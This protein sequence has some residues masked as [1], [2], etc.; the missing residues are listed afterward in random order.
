MDQLKYRE[1]LEDILLEAAGTR[2]WSQGGFRTSSWLPSGDPTKV[3]TQTQTSVERHEDGAKP[4]SRKLQT[5]THFK[6]WK[7]FAAHPNL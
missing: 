7:S 1:V 5:A 4:T 2:D 3:Q 6:I